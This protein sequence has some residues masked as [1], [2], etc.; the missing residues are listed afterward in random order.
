M[1]PLTVT[2]PRAAYNQPRNPMQIRRL[3]YV[4]CQQIRRLKYVK[5]IEIQPTADRNTSPASKYARLKYVTTSPTETSPPAFNP[6]KTACTEQ[7][8]TWR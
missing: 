7:L 4:A 1:Q 6:Q 5:T 2:Q 8:L 3:K